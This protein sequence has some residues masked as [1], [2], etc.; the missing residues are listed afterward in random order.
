[1]YVAISETI[2]EETKAAEV[3]LSEWKFSIPNGNTGEVIISDPLLDSLTVATE[4]AKSEFLKSSYEIK[5]V[6]FTT[7]RTDL[8]KNMVINIHGLPYLVKSK[9][10]TLDKVSIKTQIRGVRYT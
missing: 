3:P 4:R 5:E 1:M 9:T 8:T 6:K 10:T 7:Y 2:T